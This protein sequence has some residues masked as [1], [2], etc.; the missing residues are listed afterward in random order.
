MSPL[1]KNENNKIMKALQ[2]WHKFVSTANPDVL[3]EL[4]AEDVVFYSP[5]V[6]SPQRG[7]K[8]SRMYLLGAMQV[9][10]PGGF[11]YTKE[12]IGDRQACLEFETKI[13]ELT[14]NGVDIITW[15][16][17]GKITEFKVMIRPIKA[18][19]AVWQ[20]MAALL[21]KASGKKT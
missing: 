12:I 18:L 7:K 5:V 4:L 21:E 8:L 19:N 3:D 16:D 14:V 17:A 6:W 1:T 13:G 2:Q 15:D 10:G 20:G 11:H 9:L